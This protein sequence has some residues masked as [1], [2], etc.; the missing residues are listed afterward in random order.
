MRFERISTPVITPFND[1][2]SINVGAFVEMIE[3]LID[4]GVQQIFVGGTD[5]N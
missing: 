3:Y 2:F 1:D 5:R 4:A